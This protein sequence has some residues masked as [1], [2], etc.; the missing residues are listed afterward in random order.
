MRESNMVEGIEEFLELHPYFNVWFHS[1][2]DKPLPYGEFGLYPD[3]EVEIHGLAM[4][5]FNKLIVVGENTGR[6]SGIINGISSIN[7]E[8][9]AVSEIADE[10][11]RTVRVLDYCLLEDIKSVEVSHKVRRASIEEAGDIVRFY[12]GG[13]F[14]QVLPDVEY[15]IANNR[16]Y[17]VEDGG[18]IVSAACTF[19]ETDD[20]AIIGVVYT[21]DEFRGRG[22][23]T[24]LM[25]RLSS[26]LLHEGKRPLL[27]YDNPIGGKI[28][29]KLGFK[30]IDR[31]GMIKLEG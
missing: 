22:Y 24:S 5:Y 13:S 14:P 17:L 23:A 29:L 19:A 7:G 8:L 9:E 25:T 20:Y 31:W 21:P 2:M 16:W 6:F 11:G 15:T 28:Y 4:R 26:D 3:S 10:M 1:A 30:P 18:E 27:Y 12:E